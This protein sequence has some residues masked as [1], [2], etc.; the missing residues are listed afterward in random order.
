MT[1]LAISLALAGLA[2]SGS[3][4]ATQLSETAAGMAPGTFVELTPMNGWNQ[5]GILTPSDIAGCSDGDYI[6]QYSEKAAWDPVGRRL[7][8]VGQSH[9]NCYGGRFVSYTDATN[10]WV[11]E[12]WVP[13]ICKSGT[14]SNPCFNHGYDHSTADPATG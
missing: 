11:E 3:A 2:L 4:R 6:T 8:F 1:R 13:G 14:S 5:G 10:T 7:L 12:P 9:G